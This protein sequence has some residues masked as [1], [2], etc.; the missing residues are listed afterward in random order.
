MAQFVEENPVKTKKYIRAFWIV[1]VASHMLLLIDGLPLLQVVIS[2]V[3]QLAL[4]P[5]F[6]KFPMIEPS[7]PFTILASSKTVVEILE[8]KEC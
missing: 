7:T 5:L 6:S 8:L 4:V 2:I 1:I 3:A